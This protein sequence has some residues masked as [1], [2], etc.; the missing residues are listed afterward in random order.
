MSS[1]SISVAL[2]ALIFL[3]PA[4]AEGNPPA[5]PLPGD[6]VRIGTA[7]VYLV[8]P[9]GALE[10]DAYSV[11]EGSHILTPPSWKSLDD[12]FRRLQE[13]E[14]RLTAENQSLRASA[15][16]WTPGWKTIVASLVV[17]FA[18]GVYLGAKL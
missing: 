3:A 11:P 17:G 6:H 18:G 7:G 12:E 13:I 8:V 4:M 16:A 14:T 10:P 2:A 1:R 9:R 15:A 5:A